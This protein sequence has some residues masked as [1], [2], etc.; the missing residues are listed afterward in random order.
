MSDPHATQKVEEWLAK[1]QVASSPGSEQLN[2]VTR[3]KLDSLSE[4]SGC[5]VLALIAI[6][7]SGT[8]A[9]TASSSGE[10][11]PDLLLFLNPDP[12]TIPITLS[13]NPIWNPLLLQ[14]QGHE[15][16]V[17]HVSD[18]NVHLWDTKS[19]ISKIMWKNIKPSCL[20][21]INDSTVA[22]AGVLPSKN[23]KH[24]VYI[25]QISMEHWERT[26]TLSFSTGTG[27]AGIISDICY[28]KAIDGTGC[29]LICLPNEKSVQAT[30]MLGGRR[31]WK[32]DK[33]QLGQECC[34]VSVCTD[35]QNNVY[36][37]DY[38]QH[39]LHVLSAEDGTI[40]SGINLLP[41]DIVYPMCIR[42]SNDFMYISHKDVND[43]KKCQISKLAIKDKDF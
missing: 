35:R 38:L 23:G 13:S 40:L 33:E 8:I 32:T 29:L 14:L 2:L 21:A 34:P 4:L 10:N 15:F 43:I 1:Q 19:F 39:K 26:G 36:V 11:S 37:S 17:A 5:N 16:V 7:E 20:F 41:H 31:R 30:E 22:C 25:L 27:G 28:K 6:A 24:N 9:V 12:D 3:W 18:G 42:I